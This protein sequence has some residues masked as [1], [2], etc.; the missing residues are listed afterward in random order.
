M[1]DRCGA[2][3]RAQPAARPPPD[4]HRAAPRRGAAAAV[5]TATPIAASATARPAVSE[6]PVATDEHPEGRGLIERMITRSAARRSRPASRTEEH[7]STHR[8]P[9]QTRRTHPR[10]DRIPAGTY[11]RRARG[12]H[13]YLVHGASGHVDRGRRAIGGAQ[14]RA[15]RQLLAGTRAPSSGRTTVDGHDVRAEPE[16]MRARIGIV[17]RDERIHPRLTVEQA[18][19]SPP[20]CACRRTPHPS[21]ATAWST[22][23]STSSS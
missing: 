5:A 12:A 11:R 20:N 10:G 17:P 3:A 14:L 22:R 2:P 7:N 23:F 21:T 8:L 13:G 4:R 19:G 15:A 1:P 9:L 6:P 16:S 18:L